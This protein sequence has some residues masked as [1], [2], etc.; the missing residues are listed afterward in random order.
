MSARPPAM[1]FAD[2]PTCKRCGAPATGYDAWGQWC[3]E[4]NGLVPLEPPTE[5]QE[6]VTLLKRR[7]SIWT[8]ESGIAALNLLVA[9]AA[10][11]TQTVEALAEVHEYHCGC[12]QPGRLGLCAAQPTSTFAVLATDTAGQPETSP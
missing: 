4:H 8:D 6:A 11:H 12:D 1:P 3:E 5:V 2:P 9:Q 7:L 10:R